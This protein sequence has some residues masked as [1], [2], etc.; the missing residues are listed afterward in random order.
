MQ[1]G[2]IIYAKF[3]GFRR[4]VSR[5]G[6]DAVVNILKANAGEASMMTRGAGK[7]R[8]HNIEPEDLR[9]VIAAPET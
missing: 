5:A 6:T 9:S 4:D 7:T 1:D 3:L 8:L 2:M